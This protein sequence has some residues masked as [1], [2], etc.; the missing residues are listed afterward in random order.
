MRVKNALYPH[1]LLRGLLPLLLGVLVTLCASCASVTQ[2]LTPETFYQRDV[3]LVINGLHGVGTLVVPMAPKYDIQIT[4][5]GKSDVFVFSTCH[6]EEKGE[7][8][9]GRVHW[10]YVP[11]VLESQGGCPASI[12]S[13]SK[14]GRHAWAY[15][16]FFTPEATLE[17]DVACNGQIYHS[18]GVTVCQAKTG[19]TEEIRFAEDTRVMPDPGCELGTAGPRVFDF[20]IRHGICVY[21]FMGQVSGKVHRLTTLGYSGVLVRQ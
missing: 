5:A 7:N 1:P 19:L 2:K 4:T 10:T 15:I 16:D 12:G 21:A 11:S 8:L 17:A 14:D 6:R 18:K 13:Y 20:P 3:D 9:G